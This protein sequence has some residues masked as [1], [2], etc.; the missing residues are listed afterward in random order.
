MLFVQGR[1][2]TF[3]TP[4]ELTPALESLVPKPTLHVVAGSDHSFK[5]SRSNK[6][7]Q[8]AVVD[9]SSER[10]SSGRARS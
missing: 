3:G 10:L 1:R 2:D 5:V 7:V 9:V 8:A 4:A 6:L